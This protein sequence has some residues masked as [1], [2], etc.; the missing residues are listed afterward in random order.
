MNKIFLALQKLP[1]KKDKSRM[2][3]SIWRLIEV[4][5]IFHFVYFVVNMGYEFLYIRVASNLFDTNR[6][7]ILITHRALA[8][9]LLA[10]RKANNGTFLIVVNW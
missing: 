8:I 2:I 6:T 1:V 4:G 10:V 3:Y 5:P 7:L 9:T